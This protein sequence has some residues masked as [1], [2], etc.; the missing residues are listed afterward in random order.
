V[1]KYDDHLWERELSHLKFPPD[2]LTREQM[3]FV[4]SITPAICERG[5]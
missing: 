3:N 4:E 2:F 1:L 5:H